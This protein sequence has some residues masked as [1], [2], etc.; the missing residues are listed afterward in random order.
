MKKR[1]QFPDAYTYSI[2]LNGFAE[3]A[4]KSGTLE[5]A[6]SVYHSMSA[7]NSRVQPS[8]VHTNAMLKTCARRLNMD[9]LWGVAAKIPD[10][11][12]GAANART[13]ATILNAIRQ[14]LL[15]DAPLGELDTEKAIRK[16][17]G[18]V[19]GRR[20]WEEI[21]HKW[22]NAEVVIDED[23]VCAMGRLLLV[24]ARPRDW[25][26]VLS[27]IEQT[28]DIPRLIPRLG[29]PEREKLGY[30]HLRAPDVPADFRF[31]DDHLSP[32]QTPARGDEF[33]PIAPQGVKGLTSSLAYAQPSNNT[34]SLVM[35]A[36]QKIVGKDAGDKYWDFLTDPGT[37][38]IVPD[39]N[40]LNMRLRV[41]R[42]NRSSGEAVQLLT[43]YFEEKGV[44]PPPGTFRIAMSTCVRDKNNH[45]SLK[46]AGAILDMM[47]R[48]RENADF[49]AVEMYC[50]LAIRFPLSTG[51]DLVD[52]LAR[53]EPITKNIRI[54]LG[55][56]SPRFASMAGRNGW[57]SRE[58]REDAIE[59]LRRIYGVH[60]R[61]IFSDMI[62][63]DEKKGYKAARA[64]LSAYLARVSGKAEGKGQ[65]EGGDVGKKWEGVKEKF[66][67][68]GGE[69]LDESEAAAGIRG[70]TKYARFEQRRERS[71]GAP[72][73][74]R[75]SA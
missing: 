67:V 14:N 68:G 2:L 54:Q 28:M 5:Q 47:M 7:E 21:I 9:A 63:E 34:L 70:K 52:A 38:H 49:R 25:D 48:M 55:V 4:E 62:S 46:N 56:G 11:G 59:A 60:D 8:I 65:K 27:L 36:C 6:L 15:I 19:E 39:I 45:K 32:S 17:R 71:T 30:Q 1:A 10:K 72:D 57:L 69:T 31:D 16:D 24:G 74:Q 53:L 40:N 22:R 75:S 13:Y 23:L 51:A 33:L 58:D 66:G 37:Y 41:L 50:D 64:T 35:E 61:L 3:N 73:K 18:V 29:T 12:P 43:T 26:D 20:V 44:R 42:Q